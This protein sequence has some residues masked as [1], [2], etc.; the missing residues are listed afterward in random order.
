MMSDLGNLPDSVHLK[1]ICREY[2]RGTSELKIQYTS[3][4][5]ITNG[6]YII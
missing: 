3:V 6:I 4:K 5:Y 2:R 1:W